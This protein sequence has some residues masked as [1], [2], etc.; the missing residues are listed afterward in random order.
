MLLLMTTSPCLNAQKKEIAQARAYIKSGKNLDKAEES[1]RKLLT[2]SSNAGNVKIYMTLAESVKKQYE[3]INEKLYLRQPYDTASFFNT[4]GRMFAAFEKLDS[5]LVKQGRKRD[6]AGKTIS[7]NAEYL[8]AYRANLYNGGVYFLRNNDFSKAF[9]MFQKYLDCQTQPL[10]ASSGLDSTDVLVP[11]AASRALYCGYRLHD[12]SIVLRCRNLAMKDTLMLERTLQYLSETYSFMGD[13]AEYV[14]TLHNGIDRFPQSDYFFTHLMDYYSSISDYD[15]ALRI[16]DDAIAND[17]CGLLYLYAKSNIM[18]NIG[19]YEDCIR[20]CDRIISINDSL[21]E[22][23]YNAGISCLKI[24][25][26][27]EKGRVGKKKKQ[28]IREWYSRSL[29]YMEKYRA[30]CPEDKDNW[31]AALYNIYLNLN[32]GKEF[33]EINAL[34]RKP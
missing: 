32:M 27:M 24:A 9:Q 26:S 1:M 10:F 4:A 31:A 25:L 8:K 15:T 19:E 14:A 18:L 30:M 17:S 34:L 3:Q 21:P 2:D 20:L 22:A 13:T 12:T 28:R 29:S 33:E 6:L 7:K 23:Y 5:V 16:A 11:M